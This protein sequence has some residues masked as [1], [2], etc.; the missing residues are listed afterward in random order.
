MPKRTASSST[1]RVSKR[2]KTTPQR[3]RPG[4]DLPTESKCKTLSINILCSSSPP[5][6]FLHF[7]NV[8][9]LYFVRSPYHTIITSPQNTLFL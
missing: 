3:F 5:F 9:H 6:I 2:P 8:Q 1:R 7:R 4:S